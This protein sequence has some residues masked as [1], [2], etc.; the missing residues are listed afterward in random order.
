MNAKVYVYTTTM[1]EPCTKLKAWLAQRGI[2]YVEITKQ[3]LGE[4]ELAA[5]RRSI[6]KV[7]KA[8]SPTL[9]AVCITEDG[10]DIWVSNDGQCDIG[11]MTRRILEVLVCT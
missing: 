6:K 4:P 9:P 8:D 3:S 5:L 7:S 10:K 11:P 1:C 2:G